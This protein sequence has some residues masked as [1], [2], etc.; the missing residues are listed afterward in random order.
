MQSTVVVKAL[1]CPWQSVS[2]Y[3]YVVQIPVGRY[4]I[5]SSGLSVFS[6]RTPL[7]DHD[8]RCSDLL[9]AF[10]HE[11]GPCRI[12]KK[13]LGIRYKTLAEYDASREIYV[14]LCSPIHPHF[15][16]PY[17]SIL[18]YVDQSLPIFCRIPPCPPSSPPLFSRSVNP[19]QSRRVPYV[20]GLGWPSTAA[21]PGP[22]SRLEA[23]TPSGGSGGVA[24]GGA[25]GV[26][27]GGGVAGG[28]GVGGV[29]GRGNGG[30]GGMAGRGS[31]ESSMGAREAHAFAQAPTQEGYLNKAA[32]TVDVFPAIVEALSC[33]KRIHGH[34]KMLPT[35]R[36]SSTAPWPENLWGL[37]LG[38]LVRREKKERWREAARGEGM[39]PVSFVCRREYIM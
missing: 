15:L 37:E 28:G 11:N 36:V 25:G 17:S 14:P 21:P 26:G 19:S 35:F 32:T 16:C 9:C 1:K 10:F 39:V 30:T 34:L 27:G 22:Q 3:Q 7:P 29:R 23:T 38:K 18:L 13:Y 6:R 2:K 4:H 31:A 12:L 24:W 8:P 20:W 5:S 33:Y